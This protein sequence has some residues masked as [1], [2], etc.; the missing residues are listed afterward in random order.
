MISCITTIL[1]GFWLAHLT[2][3]LVSV[4]VAWSKSH[5]SLPVQISKKSAAKWDSNAVVPLVLILPLLVALG[6]SQMPTELVNPKSSWST[7]SLKV[8]PKSSAGNKNWKPEKILKT[9]SPTPVF[10]PNTNKNWKPEK[11]LKTKSPT[12]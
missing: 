6:I 2:W 8:P 1:D 10:Q 5:C 9:K 4:P 7:S 3:E 12:P 11:I